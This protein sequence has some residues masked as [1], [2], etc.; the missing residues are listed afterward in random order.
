[1]GAA[2]PLL[3]D[4]AGDAEPAGAPGGAPAGAHPDRLR[5]GGEPLRD[6]DGLAGGVPHRDV[7]GHGLG[8]HGRADAL[9]E[10]TL[11]AALDQAAVVMHRKDSPSLSRVVTRDDPGDYQGW[12]A[13][14]GADEEYSSP[15]AR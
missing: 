3:G 8:V 2:R 12:P 15:T 11:E 14:A 13:M 5:L 7:Q 9:V 1:D 4:G 6:R 10:D